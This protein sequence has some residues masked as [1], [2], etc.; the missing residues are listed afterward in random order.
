MH[1]Q[2]VAAVILVFAILFLLHGLLTGD[3]AG[4]VAGGL[5]AAT[6]LFLMSLRSEQ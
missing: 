4:T 2:F 6:T 1:D 5:F 3:M